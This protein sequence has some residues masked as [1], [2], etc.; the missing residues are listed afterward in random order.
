[1][2]FVGR[3]PHL[4]RL[5]G[6][7]DRTRAGELQLVVLEG[8]PGIGKTSLTTAFS[9]AAHTAGGIVLFG[10]SDEEAFLPY[11]PFH[12]ALGGYAAACE[13]GT[14]RAQLGRVEGREV[15]ALLPELA[16]RLPN[17]GTPV[18]LDPEGGRYRLFAAVSGFFREISHEAPIVLVLDDLHWADVPSLVL[19]RHLVRSLAAEPILV[20]GTARTTEGERSRRIREWLE[21]L[22]RERSV[23][24]ISLGG[25]SDEDVG[26]LL[27]RLGNRQAPEAFRAALARRTGG[28]PLFIRE[29][30]RHLI[31][32][33]A[34]LEPHGRWSS[35]L[36]LGVIGQP[37]GITEVIERRVSRLSDRARRALLAASVVG[38]D[39]EGDLLG[40]ITSLDEEE[41]AGALEEAAGAGLLAEDPGG[42]GRWCFSHAVAAE[43]VYESLS[44]TRRR[45]LH[46]RTAEALE[47]LRLSDP[48]PPF[49]ELAHHF[50][51][52][53]SAAALE[54]AAS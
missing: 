9:R 3:E 36:A 12:E 11:Q 15:L 32:S 14:L 13:T 18:P 29:I 39:L 34:L 35:S 50:Q 23:E 52:E 17:L 43:A 22:S 38:R 2:P 33:G 51:R 19:L 53:G 21:A 16:R 31:D 54:K 26:E 27:S 37:G 48:L 4:V 6:A 42:K 47:R 46:G 25:F 20:L 24:R 44:E 45:S 40:E 28:N 7:W 49:A 41:L 5:R 10:R 30:L 8:E 1:M